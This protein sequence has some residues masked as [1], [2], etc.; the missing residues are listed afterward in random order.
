MQQPEEE[1]GPDLMGNAQCLNG[2]VRNMNAGPDRGTWA[3]P[4]K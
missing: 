4:Y 1:A 2:R 3:E